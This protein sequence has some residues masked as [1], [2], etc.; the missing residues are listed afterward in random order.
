MRFTHLLAGFVL[1]IEARIGGLAA[2]RV[3]RLW[4]LRPL[5]RL[6]VAR[7]SGLVAA[8]VTCLGVLR[9]VCLVVERVIRLGVLRP[10]CLV[11]V[12]VGGMVALPTDC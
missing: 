11:R 10:S 3:T 12:G 1:C 5:L 4:V 2:A 8:R 9:A 7:N 6:V